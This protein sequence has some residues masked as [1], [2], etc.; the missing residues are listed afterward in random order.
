MN[1]FETLAAMIRR[2]G[3]AALVTLVEV[4]GSSPRDAGARMAVRADGAFSGTVGGGALEWQALAEA[5]AILASPDGPRRRLMDRALGPD[6]GQCCGGRVRLALE[7]LGTE[8]LPRIEGL[9][10]AQA[11]DEK[12][13]AFPVMLFGAGHVGRALVLAL[14]ALPLRVTWVD[15]RQNAF[16]RHAPANVVAVQGSDTAGL[17]ASAPDGAAILAMTHSH[18]LD[19]EIVAVALAERRFAYVGVIGSV[20]KRARFVTQLRQTGLADELIETLICPIG[21]PEIAGKEP[22]VIAASVA[23]QLLLVRGSAMAAQ[24]KGSVDLA[25]S[26]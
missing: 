9:A 26:R 3:R 4:K 8:D 16:P 17:I 1:L 5:Q 24:T 10:A 6:L 22:A 20:T 7:R 25:S 23:A 11:E 2:D 21:L 18:A 15:G 12:A 19:L 14:A 13:A